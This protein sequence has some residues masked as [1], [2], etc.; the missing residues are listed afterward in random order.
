MCLGLK[1]SVGVIIFCSDIQF[2]PTRQGGPIIILEGKIPI[3]DFDKISK[4]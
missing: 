4:I 2:S 1:R 3:I